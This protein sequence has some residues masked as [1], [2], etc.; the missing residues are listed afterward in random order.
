MDTFWTW[1]IPLLVAAGALIIPALTYCREKTRYAAQKKAEEVDLAREI[2]ALALTLLDPVRQWSERVTAASQEMLKG[3]A[4]GQHYWSVNQSFVA[5][6]EVPMVVEANNARLGILKGAAAPL[7]NAIKRAKDF[8]AETLAEPHGVA[9][10]VRRLQEIDEHLKVA[11][12]VL[13]TL[14]ESHPSQG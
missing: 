1:L 14:S 6:I 9:H 8:K 10:Q 13:S 11:C 12:A 5:Q 4:D 7:S 3:G 2:R